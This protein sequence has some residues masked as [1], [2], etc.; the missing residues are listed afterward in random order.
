METPLEKL[1]AIE[2]LRRFARAKADPRPDCQACAWFSL[3]QQGC[4]RFVGVGGQRGHYLCRAY[5]RF[6]AH[7]QEGFMALRDRVLAERGALTPSP[8]PMRWRGEKEC[9][10]PKAPAQPVGRN[11][12]CPCGSGRKY[13]HCCG[14]KGAG[15]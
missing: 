11:D 8:S 4:P 13:K 6:F 15:A 5:Q 12:Q 1:F 10:A 3:C 2:G 14:R 9:V 7:S